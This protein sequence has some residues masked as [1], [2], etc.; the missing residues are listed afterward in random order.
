MRWAAARAK[1]AAA[2]RAMA[3]TEGQP[4]I[5]THHTKYC[6]QVVQE[7]A[8]NYNT[9][10]Q[11]AELDPAATTTGFEGA[12]TSRRLLRRGHVRGQRSERTSGDA[13]AATGAAAARD[14]GRGA[15]ITTWPGRAGAAVGAPPP[16][17]G[18]TVITTQQWTRFTR[19]EGGRS[20]V[21]VH[22]RSRQ[23]CRTRVRCGDTKTHGWHVVGDSAAW[24]GVVNA[25]SGR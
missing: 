3:P 17:S 23:R 14:G 5:A 15:W 19:R 9:A 11:A 24:E 4:E 22:M 2:G 13:G 21:E 18:M 8:F 1:Q 16:C 25:P 20:G 7:R 6:S 10:Q 12:P